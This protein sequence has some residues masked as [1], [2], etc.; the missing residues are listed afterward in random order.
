MKKKILFLILIGLS[1]ISNAQKSEFKD[2]NL[3]L[4]LIQQGVDKNGNGTFENEELDS[5]TKLKLDEKNIYDLS[6]IDSFKNLKELNL[7]KNNILNFDIINKLTNLE[8]LVIGDNRNVGKLD[9]SK[10]EKL[11]GLFAFRNDLVEIKIGS[12]KIKSLYLQGNLFNSLNT[13]YFAD[14]E[15]LNLD[16]CQNLV[17]L[18]LS[19]NINLVQL[20]VM[21]TKI[22]KLNISNN[23]KLKTF[24]IESN[25][26]LEKNKD[27]DNLKAMPIIRSE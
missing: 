20:Y 9:L 6:G 27:Q 10:L 12:K 3:K 1:K 4:A 23:S 15:T 21:D 8:K 16:G 2:V 7:R 17:S 13:E 26:V 5:I 25:V 22:E 11:T 19:K 18:D 14:L 24:Y